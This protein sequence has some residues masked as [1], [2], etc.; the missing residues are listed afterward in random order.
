[1]SISRP[2]A[3]SISSSRKPGPSV[4]DDTSNR[5]HA[6]RVIDIASQCHVNNVGFILV[7]EE[8]PVEWKSERMQLALSRTDL[9]YLPLAWCKY[10]LVSDSSNH[11]SGILTN[12]V[13]IATAILSASDAWRKRRGETVELPG[14]A[15]HGIL[16]DGHPSIRQTHAVAIRRVPVV[17][18]L[19]PKSCFCSSCRRRRW[20][21]SQS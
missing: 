19:R 17:A 10:G 15:Y 20:N 3:N 11:K 2:T 5:L 7:R 6:S 4:E 12:V 1:M 16:R 21:L 13:E 8:D 14:L 9:Q 18:R